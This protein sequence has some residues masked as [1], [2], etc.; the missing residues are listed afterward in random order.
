LRRYGS[1]RIYS[2]GE[3]LFEAGKVGPGMFVVL[4]GLVAITQRDG[5]GHVTPIAEQGAGAP[6][7]VEWHEPDEA[8]VSRPDL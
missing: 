6:A 4:S 8:R 7:F 1:L 2:D 5:L 3:K